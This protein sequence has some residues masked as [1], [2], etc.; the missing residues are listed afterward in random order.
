MPRLLSK[1]AH[2]IAV[3]G[4]GK[5]NCNNYATFCSATR[6]ILERSSAACSTRCKEDV[7]LQPDIFAFLAIVTSVRAGP[8]F[9]GEADPPRTHYSLCT[10]WTV[11]SVVSARALTFC[12]PARF[13]LLLVARNGRFQSFDLLMLFEE[14]I[15]QHRVH[16]VV[17][18]RVWFPFLVGQHQTVIHLCDLFGNQTELRC[19]FASLL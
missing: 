18:H 16:C 10:I 8:T 15:E 12:R 17:A 1:T 19:A 7:A 9:S 11:R 2:R 3:K 13:D 5:N 6:L 14:L 4:C